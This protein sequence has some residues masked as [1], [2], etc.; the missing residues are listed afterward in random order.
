MA[1]LAASSLPALAQ[2]EAPQVQAG[3][4]DD[5]AITVDGRLDEA[6][7]SQAGVIEDLTQQ[8]PHPGAPTPYHTK[9]LLLRG[10]H[11]LYIGL[12]CDDPDLSKLATH[13]L[14]RDGNQGSDDNVLFMLDTFGTKR[15]AYVFQVNASG[16]MADGL[17][18]PTAAI[19][20]YNGVD[21][22]WDGIWQA[23]VVQGEHGWTA[24][25]AIDTRSLQFTTGITRWGFN[26][27]RNV[28]R[29]LLTLDWAGV[30]LDSSVFQ[31]TRE[32][33]LTGVQDM[34][35]GKG[36][37][38]QPYGLMKYKTGNGTTSNT[39]V[40]IKYNFNPA[41][42]GLFTYHTD[43]AEAEA[44]Q[45]QI[46]TGRFPLFF[47]EKRQFFL[48]GSNL[49]TFGYNQG[50]NFIPFNSRNIGLVNGLEVPLNEGVKLIGQSDNGSLA[51]LDTQMGG[52]SQ[53]DATNLFVGRGTYNLDPE[54]QVGGIV[55]HGDPTGTSSNT[56]T[57]ADATWKTSN[58]LGDKNLNLSGWAAHS[59]G[60]LPAGS[61]N[62]YGVDLE[63]PNDLWYLH[64]QFSQWGDALDPALGFLPRPGTRYS[65][66]EVNYQPRPAA[67]SWFN[68]VHRFWFYGHYYEYDGVGPQDGGKQSAEWFF[69]PEMLTQGGWYWEFDLY[70]DFDRP[71]GAFDLV[72]D[73]SVPQGPYT[74]NRRR[75]QFNSPQSEALWWE[76]ID[77]QGTYY[78]GTAHHPLVQVNW[79]TPSGQLVLSASQEWLFYYQP[80]YL[81]PGQPDHGVTRLTTLTGTYA[82]TPTFYITTQMQY[83]NGIP[84]VSSNTQLH[85]IV[86]DASNVYLVFNHGVV[87]ETDG[88]GQPVIENGNEVILKV[89]WDFRN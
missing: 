32:G 84:G 77:S 37:D 8:S 27:S 25:I 26:L 63:Y 86:E 4:V 29:D 15:F 22:N 47:P 65:I 42:A 64:Q 67:D 20:S 53:S 81:N 3:R 33:T 56:F 46:N 30:T 17:Q 71:T 7:W 54:L 21:Y 88:L 38:V 16:A 44:D 39:G 55:T 35:Q 11:T 58:F 31:L 51:L 57:G 50:T 60:D 43:F 89:Q 24:E 14:V 48:Q 52:S 6:A 70:Q 2:D 72:P 1:M 69:S 28:P 82:F 62:G 87:T 12:V 85:W 36:L 5:G 41:L 61:P 83:N 13:T 79:N 75:I 9:V 19:N 74:W 23:K 66:T 80:Q 49:F 10:N 40:D 45:Q 78:A 68:W 73:V 76:F 18:S 34:E 59:A